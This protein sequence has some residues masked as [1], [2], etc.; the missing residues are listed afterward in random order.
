MNMLVLV[1]PPC[2]F[3]SCLNCEFPKSQ[4][5][6]CTSKLPM[7]LHREAAAPILQTTNCLFTST[8]RSVRMHPSLT[9]RAIHDDLFEVTTGP[10]STTV[11][12]WVVTSG[13]V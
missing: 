13:R 8:R 7:H 6:W 5:T 11:G 2:T 12:F 3:I 4:R 1:E 10:F 9:T